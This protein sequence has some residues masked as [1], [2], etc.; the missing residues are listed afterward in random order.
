MSRQNSGCPDQRHKRHGCIAAGI[1]MKHATT[2][3][4]FEY[5]NRRRGRRRVPARSNIDPADIRHVLGDTFLL[6]ADFAGDIRFR[7]AGTRIC[8]LFAREIKGDAFNSLWRETN[9][10]QVKELLTAILSEHVGAVAGVLGRTADGVEVELE[11]LLLPL[12]PDR[13][14]RIRALGVLAPLTPPYW[15]DERPVIEL[16]LRTLRHIGAEQSSMSAPCFGRAHEEPRAR[17]GFLVYS[18]GRELQ[19]DKPSSRIVGPPRP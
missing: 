14:T 3:E 6:T 11:L 17:H 10:E 9:Q 2:R 15:L 7:L 13:R 4:V 19:T 16:E 5:W 12:A 18:G 1:E 8:A